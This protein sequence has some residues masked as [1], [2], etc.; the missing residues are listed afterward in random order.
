M[1]LAGALERD[2]KRKLLGRLSPKILKILQSSNAFCQWIGQRQGSDPGTSSPRIECLLITRLVHQSQMCEIHEARNISIYMGLVSKSVDLSRP[3]VFQ[4]GA[5][6]DLASAAAYA[7]SA[8]PIFSPLPPSLPAAAAVDYLASFPLFLLLLCLSCLF[9]SFPLA[10][11]PICLSHIFE[12]SIYFQSASNL[13]SC[14]C[15]ICH[16]DIIILQ[17]LCEAQAAFK[18][19]ND[20]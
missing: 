15:R 3:R 17:I 19:Q 8:C 9:S 10:S 2:R 7:G 13:L 20:F 14:S 11:L 1:P 12:S 5:E 6:V 4:C 18:I 16:Y